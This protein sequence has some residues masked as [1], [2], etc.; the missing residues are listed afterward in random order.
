VVALVRRTRGDL[1][2]HIDSKVVVIGIKRGPLWRHRKNAFQWKAFWD[3]LGQ[4]G[5]V[6]HKIPAHA[7][8]E[9]VVAAGLSAEAH[10]ANQVADEAA[11]EAARAAQLPQEVV[12]EVFRLDKEAF[13]IQSHLTAVG[14]EVAS[15]A[16]ELY[17]PSSSYQRR[18]E[19]RFRAKARRNAEKE[20][21]RLSR[22]RLC[23]R[24]NTCL[25]CYKKPAPGQSKADF[26][27]T[28]CSKTPHQ[29]H[30]SHA[31]QCTRG[32]WWC[33]TCGASS[34]KLFRALRAPCAPPGVHGRR[35][36][37]KLAQGE[38]P[39]HLRAWPDEEAGET[40]LLG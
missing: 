6:V 19:A 4:R 39:P 13:D 37:E 21:L 1:E 12:A 11:E 25:D 20:A 35:C 33:K 31:L 16:V 30:P 34:S 15:R 40:L 3:A 24:T 7:S 14:L 32:L 8:L 23:S 17:G 26:L 38:L 5:I 10:K 27:N 29:V 9:T 18:L 22:H 2:I 28:D 36:R